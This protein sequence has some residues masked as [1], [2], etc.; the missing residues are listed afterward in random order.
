MIGSKLFSSNPNVKNNTK[1]IFTILN[2]LSNF[3]VFFEFLSDRLSKIPDKTHQTELLE[4]FK[5]C[6]KNYNSTLF[7]K[8]T[9]NILTLFSVLSDEKQKLLLSEIIGDMLKQNENVGNILKEAPLQLFNYL[10]S[11]I[12]SDEMKNISKIEPKPVVMMIDDNYN[13]PTHIVNEVYN[14]PKPIDIQSVPKLF[15]Q[16]EYKSTLSKSPLLI[17]P[18]NPNLNTHL[19]TPISIKP[20][21]TQEHID[22]IFTNLI[23]MIFSERVTFINNLEFNLCRLA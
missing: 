14:I 2:K 21:F 20:Q 16:N 12:N 17:K 22:N 19:E 18:N 15:I 8:I 23:K 9:K 7:P 10:K 11:N 4:F 6:V 13:K 3:E 1:S 5:L